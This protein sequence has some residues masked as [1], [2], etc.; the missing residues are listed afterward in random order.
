MRKCKE[1]N[2]EYEEYGPRHKLCRPCKR[3]Y[4]NAIYANLSP[5]KLERRKGLAKQRRQDNLTWLRQKKADSGCFDCGITDFRV[6]DFDHLPQYEKEINLGDVC[7]HG[8]SQERIQE[9]VDKCE[10]VCSNCHR[11]RTYE[12]NNGTVV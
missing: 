5:E 4:D 1:C 10:V 11:I 7:R 6:L 12:R 3:E 2:N 9:E 8:W